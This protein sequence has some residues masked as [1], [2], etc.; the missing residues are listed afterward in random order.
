MEYKNFAY[1]GTSLD[2]YIADKNGG[3]DWLE[4]IPN[5][6]HNDMGYGA[7]TSQIDALVWGR[8]TFETVCGFDMEWPF[9]KPVFV[10]SKSLN[11]F[12]EKLKD[13]VQLVSGSIPEILST[14]HKRGYHRL[15]IDG[16]KLIQSF[17]AEDLIDEMTITI[18]PT[19][20]GSGI[21]L[22]GELIEKLDFE[23][24]KSQVFLGHI[25]QNHY[26]RVRY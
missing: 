9:Q 4:R 13:K 10:A 5:P 24:I 8:N 21:S 6:D 17:L 7:F 2:G 16:G 18:I 23:L 11:E 3:L 14:I 15:Y 12:P 25:V 22:F 26:R 20:L 1:I 19:L